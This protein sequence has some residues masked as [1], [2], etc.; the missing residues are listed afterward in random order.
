MTKIIYAKTALTGGAANALDGIDGAVLSDG[1]R[2]LVYYG[3]NSY[4]YILDADSG[5]TES[6]RNIIQPDNNAG[7]KRW[8]LQLEAGI[9][10][11]PQGAPDAESTGAIT[12]H[13]ADMLTGIVTGNPSA[14]RAYTLDSG[15]NC[16]AG[17]SID[18]G[19]AFDWYLINI[20]TDATFI[21]TITSPGADHTLVG[22][23]KVPSNSTTT[24]GLWGTCGAML[25]TRKTAANTFITYRL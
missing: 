9:K 20:A 5:A 12:V 22:S 14:A 3:G 15:A 11:K 19:E 16:D 4:D 13:I 18:I 8:V 10:I 25:R 6:K 21:I 24:G 1:D 23:S 7:T 2:A 17:M